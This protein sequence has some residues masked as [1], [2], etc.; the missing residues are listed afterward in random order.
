MQFA[1]CKMQ[2]TASSLCSCLSSLD[3]CLPAPLITNT[4]SLRTGRVCPA[5]C[6]GA[7]VLGINQNPVTIK[8]MEVSIVDM[9]GGAG[10]NRQRQSN[11]NVCAGL[12][13]HS[14]RSD[15]R[16][17]K[18]CGDASCGSAGN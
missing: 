4:F 1:V 5:P 16:G 2:A 6:E 17:C 7:C 11:A 18:C 12:R 9:V 15:S 14:T 13:G 8:T 3:S 10:G